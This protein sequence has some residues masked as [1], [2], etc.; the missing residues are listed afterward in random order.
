VFGFTDHDLALTFDDTTF[1][2]DSGFTASEL[3]ASDDLGVDAQDAEGVLSSGRITEG[4]IA[5]GLWDGAAVEVWR[6]NWAD[7]SQRVLLRR[8]AIGEVRRGKIAFTAEMRSMAHVLDQPVG[9]TFQATCDAVLG[10]ARCGV[11]LESAGFKGSG[12]VASVLRDRAFTATGLGAFADGLFTF[13]TLVWDTG[14]NAGATVEVA[15]FEKAASG[16]VTVT[17]VEAPVQAITASDSFTIRA[18]CDKLFATCRDVFA[19]TDNFRGF[20]HIPGNDTVLR[21]AGQGRAN[22]GRVL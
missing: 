5:A 16:T 20:P 11:N 18:G 4:D 10:D 7:T 17:L 15:R 6:V 14:T 22:D 1:E 9:R 8:G 19:N 21:Y 2:P 3:R 12:A 13:G